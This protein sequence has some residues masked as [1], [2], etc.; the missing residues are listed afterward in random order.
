MPFKKGISGNYS[1]RPNGSQN[2]ST[3]K[4][5]DAI[6]HFLQENF[7]VI[8]DDFDNLTPKDRIRLYCDLLQYGLP[9]LQSVH[10]E[11]EFDRLPEDQLDYL[12][13][14]LSNGEFQ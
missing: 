2:Q 4:I 8:I 12:L 11:A 9:K 13:N 14:K 10:L 5:R 3:K 6:I 1:G 7:E